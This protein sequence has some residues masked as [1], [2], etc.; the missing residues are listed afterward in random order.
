MEEA[1]LLWK[2]RH[3]IAD[4]PVTVLYMTFAT[5]TTVD[6]HQLPVADVET[7]RRAGV[8][9]HVTMLTDHYH[10]ET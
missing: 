2:R 7:P 6:D 1:L 8:A 4:V 9:A 3:P 5:S 10:A